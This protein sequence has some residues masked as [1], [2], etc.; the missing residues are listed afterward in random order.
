M[1]M[2]SIIENIIQARLGKMYD[3]LLK[4]E[5]NLNK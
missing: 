3:L 1:D 4:I 5:Q 2:E